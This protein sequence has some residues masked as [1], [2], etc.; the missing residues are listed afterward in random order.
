[1]KKKALI[2][3]VISLVFVLALTA[4]GDDDTAESSESLAES[5]VESSVDAS[6]TEAITP[7][8][9]P[10]PSPIATPTPTEMP[11]ETSE[12]IASNSGS[13]TQTTTSTTQ[14]TQSS[15]AQPAS[16]EAT[17]AA[18]EHVHTWVTMTGY[19]TETQTVHHDGC[20]VCGCCGATFNSADAVNNHI[21]NNTDCFLSGAGYVGT[22]GWDETVETQV[23]YTYEVCSECGAVKENKTKHN[24]AH[25]VP[26]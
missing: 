24:G 12:T 1:M 19:T 16:T 26:I 17:P 4:C 9:T 22:P 18:T 14:E 10:S 6:E 3:T 8:A 20:Y 11:E 2:L 15:A 23:P 21:N 13:D 5:A 7:S 25:P